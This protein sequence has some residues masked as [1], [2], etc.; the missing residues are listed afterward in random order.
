MIYRPRYRS[1]DIVRIRI[2][3]YQS[4]GRWNAQLE[5]IV[6]AMLRGASNPDLP[7]AR[8]SCP[9]LYLRSASL[10]GA[11]SHQFIRAEF[12]TTVPI[13]GTYLFL[14]WNLWNKYKKFDGQSYF[15]SRQSQRMRPILYLLP[16]I[17]DHIYA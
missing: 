2:Y 1:R 13:R 6:G 3:S 5:N 7:S 8:C 14:P 17:D 16:F 12:T 15:N 11:G 9:C 4:I 10:Y